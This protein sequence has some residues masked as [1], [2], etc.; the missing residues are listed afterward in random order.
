M[1]N[2]NIFNTGRSRPRILVAPLDWGLGHATRCI[3]II[4]ELIKQG[5]EVL[6]AANKSVKFLL[7][8]E[9]PGIA[10]LPIQG[11]KIKY[12]RNGSLLSLKLLLQF[13]KIF[14]FVLKENLWLKKIINKYRI[15]AVISD[16][17]FGLYNKKVI[18]VYITHQLRI[19]PGNKIFEKFASKIHY[20]FIEKYNCCWVPDNKENDLAGD[21]SHPA[22]MPSNVI[23]IGPLSRFERLNDVALKYNLL[24][25]LS[26]PEPQ[27][28]I[29]EKAILAQLKTFKKSVLL[30][31]GLPGEL[32]TQECN[33]QSIEIIN[34]LSS[35]E[36][37]T[38]FLQSEMIISRSGYS[39]IMDLVKL[40]K[41]AILVP[42]PGQGEQEFLAK[43]LMK[44]KYF[45]S[46]QQKGFS[47]NKVI[48]EAIS[49]PFLKPQSSD[50]EYKK[51]ISE[52]VQSLKAGK[53]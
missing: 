29:F 11:Y 23:Y 21:L 27:R 9:F 50:D 14:F 42:T 3:P 35:Q 15:D 10:F 32:G 52:F 22:N 48:D 26:G 2:D 39:T 40:G 44:K 20:H 16:N 7:K 30:V 46:A 41:N 18:S 31:R 12:S 45:Y 25:A 28:T 5:C 19:K 43:Y 38:A 36:L 1:I 49:F 33:H 34:H 24:I 4:K 37:N 6:I 13:P 8:K 53:N 17:R 51:I 47:L